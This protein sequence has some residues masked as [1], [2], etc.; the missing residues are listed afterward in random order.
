[1]Y[2]ILETL[3]R[4][5]NS[6]ILWHRSTLFIAGWFVGVRELIVVNGLPTCLYY[7][8]TFMAYVIYKCCRGPQIDEPY[9][10]IIQQNRALL[11]TLTGSHLVKNFPAFY[12]NRRLITASTSA[13]HL[14]LSWATLIQSMLS[15]PTSWR[16]V[17][18]YNPTYA[19]LYK[20]IPFL[21]FPHQNSIYTS[22]SKQYMS[23]PSHSS[24]FYHPNNIR[25]E[26]HIIKLLTM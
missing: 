11:E 19:W 15:N 22:P 23:R 8:V 10:L 17:L 14:S 20:V 21:R 4:V 7:C 26:V 9:L 25:W 18:Y 24:P 2:F 5:S 13:R 12:G 6:N 3:L 1:M 16:S